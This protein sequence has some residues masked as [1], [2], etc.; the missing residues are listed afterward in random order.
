MNLQMP[1]FALILAGLAL[2]HPSHGEYF[3][4]SGLSLG[5]GDWINITDGDWETRED[6]GTLPATSVYWTGWGW[7]GGLT[8]PF[9]SSFKRIGH[10]TRYS[11]GD[12]EVS[13]GKRKGLW[14]PRLTLKFPLYEWSVEDASLNELYIGSGAWDLALGLGGRLPHGM[15]PKRLTLHFDLDGSAV[16]VPGLADHGSWHGIGVVQAAYA[17]G[18]RWKTGVNTLLLFD[19]RV[20]IPSY[21]DQEG[22]VRFSIVPGGVLGARLFQ[23]TYVD[24]KAGWC[25]LE[26]RRLVGAKYAERSQDAYHFGLSI[27][28]AFK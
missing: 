15:L 3:R 18:G 24:L 5:F 14:S 6:Y 8:V 11:L 22:E 4:I 9:K 13:F 19:R 20:W 28:Q 27:Y 16:L 2:A 23:S 17:F 1:L 10:K 21:W 26:Y 7:N 12:G 25:L